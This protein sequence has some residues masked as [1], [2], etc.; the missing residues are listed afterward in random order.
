MPTSEMNVCCCTG[1]IGSCTCRWCAHRSL[2]SAG[3]SVYWGDWEIRPPIDFAFKLMTSLGVCVINGGAALQLMEELTGDW[4]SSPWMRHPQQHL[5]SSTVRINE[6]GCWHVG[7]MERGMTGNG[8]MKGL[9][10]NNATVTCNFILTMSM[11]KWFWVQTINMGVYLGNIFR[12]W[13]QLIQLEFLTGVTVVFFF[14][15]NLCADYVM[16]F[17]DK[18]NGHFPF[19]FLTHSQ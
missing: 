5:S 16:V 8:I 6:I 15:C 11:E 18:G 14:L 7:I 10:V 3:S 13:H 9:C 12:Y 17:Q 19:S 2:P 1:G 4:A